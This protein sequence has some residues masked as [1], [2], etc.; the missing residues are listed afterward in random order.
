MRRPI[1]KC[2]P[3]GE[4]RHDFYREYNILVE[5]ESDKGSLYFID[6]CHE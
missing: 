4:S 5:S 1:I 2:S 6:L 3:L